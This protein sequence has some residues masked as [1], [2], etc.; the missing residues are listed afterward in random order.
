VPQPT[1]PRLIRVVVL[2]FICCLFRNA[3]STA[4]VI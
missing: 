4:G 2:E 3:V 1:A